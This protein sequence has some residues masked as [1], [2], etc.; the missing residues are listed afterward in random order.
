MAHVSD[1]TNVPIS[2]AP[3]SSSNMGSPS[4]SLPD[5][6]GTGFRACTMEE[7]T[8]SGPDWLLSPRSHV[9]RVS[10]GGGVVLF[11][12]VLFC[13]VLFCF[14][15]FCFVLFCFVLFC[16]VLFCFVLF[17]FVLFCFVLFCFVLFCF[18]LFCFVLFCYSKRIIIVRWAD[19]S[20]L[21]VD[22]RR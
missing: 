18:V 6:Q 5:L 15:L 13:F 17:C 14:V 8:G 3:A 10:R 20:D 9:K 7:S 12:F 22:F 19:L 4:G 1:G 2:P 21:F 11:C 16:F